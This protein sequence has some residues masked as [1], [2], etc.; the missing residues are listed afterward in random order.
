MNEAYIS[1]TG[2]WLP[3]RI[4]TNGDLERMVDTS[5]AWII[6]RTGIKERRIVA[7][8][9]ATSDLAIG[10]SR[11]AIEAAGLT[12]EDMGAIILAT[13]TPDTYVPACAVYVQEALGAK[14]AFAFDLNA[15]CTGFVYATAIGAGMIKSALCR[16][17]LVIGA[18]SLSRI[19]DYTDRNSCILFGDGAGAAV[20]SPVPEGVGAQGSRIV[21]SYLRSNGSDADLIQMPAGGSR[22]PASAETLAAREHFLR[23]KGKE[24]FRFAT[25]TLAELLDIAVERNGI[26]LQDLD[27]VIPHQVNYRIIE[28]ALRRSNL[29]EEKIYLNLDR[30]GNTSA[31]SVPIA[32]DEAVRNGRLR[33]GNLVLLV[34]F[35]AGMTWGYNLIRW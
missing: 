20:I 18:E 10:A 17:V 28:S 31:A 34:A 23:L 24:V 27:L 19:V 2:S 25:K 32:I 30:F 35:G 6:Q 8:G 15:A 22:K 11:R 4:L 9:Q 14:N 13:I 3:E 33:K 16:H 21:D 29:P 1:G 12:P 26:G 7:E 5:D